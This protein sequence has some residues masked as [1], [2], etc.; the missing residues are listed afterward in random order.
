MFREILDV[1]H[2]EVPVATF[3]RFRGRWALEVEQCPEDRKV[4][5]KQN[6]AW[7]LYRLAVEPS[8]DNIYLYSK[9]ML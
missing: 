9:I 1:E 4:K 3:V 8:K 6:D 5:A 2:L 7:G